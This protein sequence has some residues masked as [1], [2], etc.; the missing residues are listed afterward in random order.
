MANTN[1]YFGLIAAVIAVGFYYFVQRRK[2][3]SGDAPTKNYSGGT[4]F[5]NLY[6]TDFTAQAK[7][8]R[9]D[10]VVG[11]QDE[12]RKLT[13]VLA[14]RCKNNA[15][16]SRVS[17]NGLLITKFLTRW[18]KSGFWRLMWRLLCRE[19]NTAANLNSGQKK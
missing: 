8:G 3:M 11:R 13:Q 7:L 17:R 15:I 1:Y 14:R 5:L 19:L 4:P 9:L 12:V 18:Q 6:T 10:P 2:E 16:L